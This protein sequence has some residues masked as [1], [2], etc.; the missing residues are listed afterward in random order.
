MVG[1]AAPS[2]SSLCVIPGRGG[3]RRL[4]RKNIRLLGGKPLIGWVI[5]A[6]IGSGVFG[7]V[8]VSTEDDEIAEVSRDFGAEVPYMRPAH[9]AADHGSAG[10]VAMEMAGTLQSQGYEFGP[11]CVADASSPLVS[12]DDFRKAFAVFERTGATVL[13]GLARFDHPPQRALTLEAGVAKPMWGMEWLPRQSQELASGY[14]IIGSP[15]FVRKDHLLKTG[16]YFG[17][18]MAGYEIPRDRATDIDTEDDLLL[19]EFIVDRMRRR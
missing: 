11:V 14:R 10:K 13:F 2:S 1:Q 12:A 5:E 4:P 19:A 3:S 17:G 16:N 8:C 6:A 18:T 7:H 9:L 15:I